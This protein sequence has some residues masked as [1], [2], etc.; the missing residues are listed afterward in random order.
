[1]STQWKEKGEELA[2]DGMARRIMPNSAHIH[3]ARLPD[4]VSVP[5]TALGGAQASP[6]AASPRP[7]Y[8][9][10][11]SPGISAPPQSHAVPSAPTPAPPSRPAPAP[12]PAAPAAMR[13]WNAGPQREPVG[14]R[15][16]Q[17]NGIYHGQGPRGAGGSGVMGGA[18]V[19]GRF[20][21]EH[22]RD[23][24]QWNPRNGPQNTQAQNF[25]P[26]L[27]PVADRP[28]YPMGERIGGG[29]LGGQRSAP[30]PQG[31]DNAYG[32]WNGGTGNIGRAPGPNNPPYNNWHRP[33]GSDPRLFRR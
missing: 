11:Q 31:S 10:L 21:G 24:R 1:M 29:I 5:R 2:K 15:V 19:P 16:W 26:Y 22:Q 9:S 30:F 23:D 28:P 14:G 8:D 3:N 18:G 33:N 27:A 4:P 7:A 12:P 6:Y 17:D 13:G 32:G 20:M 25:P